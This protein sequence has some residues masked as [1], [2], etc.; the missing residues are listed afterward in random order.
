[1]A[2]DGTATAY[3]R[4]ANAAATTARAELGTADRDF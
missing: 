1:V 3:D 4:A 2:A